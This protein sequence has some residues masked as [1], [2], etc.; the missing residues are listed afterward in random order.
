MR[1]IAKR[2][3][4]AA[5]L[6]L[7]LSAPALAGERPVAVELFTSQSCYSCPPAEAF[8]N[9]L[10]QMKEVVALEFHVDSWDQIVYGGAGQWK[11]VF[12][13]KAWTDRQRAYAQAISRGGR[14][15]TP[16]MV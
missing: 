1:R 10:A 7:P 3:A 2:I 5:T 14:A 11:D 12:S 15:Y 9:Q 13:Q 8:L 4:L 16:Q 6:L